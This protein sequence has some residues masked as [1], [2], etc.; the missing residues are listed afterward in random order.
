MRGRAVRLLI[1]LALCLLAG[2]RAESG[3]GPGTPAVPGT[4]VEPAAPPEPGATSTAPTLLTASAS[5]AEVRDL[6]PLLD[7][8]GNLSLHP[9]TESW[10]ITDRRASQLITLPGA[11]AEPQVGAAEAGVLALVAAP[12]GSNVEVFG[13]G[14]AVVRDPTGTAVVGLAPPQ[15][16]RY[17]LVGTDLLRLVARTG[18][19]ATD[20]VPVWIGV[21]TIGSLTWGEREGG[22]SI[23]VEPNDWTRAAG[24][25]GYELLWAQLVAVEP[26]ADAP[27]MHDQ[28]VC[29]AV[30]EP[31]KGTWN[32]EPWRPDVGLLAVMA[33]LCNPT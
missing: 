23:A 12:A 30:G 21:E 29:H 17:E 9:F 15:G 6:S 1:V 16:A 18:G 3:P 2:C 7:R 5:A 33:A 20:E 19:L 31:D 11:P 26:E 4:S 27:G 24:Q 10:S 32:L 28:L 8:A 14:S 25:A 13:D 22:R